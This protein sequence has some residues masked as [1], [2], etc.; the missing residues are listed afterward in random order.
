MVRQVSI[1]SA[2]AMALAL[3]PTLGRTNAGQP[4]VNVSVAAVTKATSVRD[5]RNRVGAPDEAP[6]KATSAASD[7]ARLSEYIEMHGRAT[8]YTGRASFMPWS[9]LKQMAN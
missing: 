3:T 1:V 6:A 9:S 5:N 4:A 7:E 8:D 2:L